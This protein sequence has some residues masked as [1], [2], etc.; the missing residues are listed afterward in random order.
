[1]LLVAM[2]ILYNVYIREYLESKTLYA[3]MSGDTDLQ[4]KVHLK[5]I[6]AW[7]M[8]A[9]AK[10]LELAWDMVVHNAEDLE[11][12]REPCSPL[13]MNILRWPEAYA[14]RQ[15]CD[16]GACDSVESPEDDLTNFGEV[17]QTLAF[18]VFLMPMHWKQGS[19]GD[20]DAGVVN[21]LKTDRGDYFYCTDCNPTWTETNFNRKVTNPE[22][23]ARSANTLRRPI[24]THLREEVAAQVRRYY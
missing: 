15:V 5:M 2:C 22:T 9:R 24:P 7:K 10:Q 4:K 21:N 16:G 3:S 17:S 8:L 13:F 19:D 1:M 20:T 12:S 14:R 6:R 23:S 18:D 11:Q